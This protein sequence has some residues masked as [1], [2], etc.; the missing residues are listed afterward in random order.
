MS[1]NLWRPSHQAESNP[2][3]GELVNNVQKKMQDGDLDQIDRRC[4]DR[5]FYDE[6]D[7][8]A[9]DEIAEEL[10]DLDGLTRADHRF[11]MHLVDAFSR[12]VLSWGYGAASSKDQLFDYDSPTLRRQAD[13]IDIAVLTGLVGNDI[14]GKDKE[15]DKRA[16]EMS[17]SIQDCRLVLGTAALIATRNLERRWE[18]DYAGFESTS[19][20]GIRSYVEVYADFHGDFRMRETR[21][22]DVIRDPFGTE[23]FGGPEPEPTYIAGYHSVEPY[24]LMNV[25]HHQSK[26]MDGT[27]LT[28]F[29]YTITKRVYEDP[30]LEVQVGN[31]GDWGESS[32]EY[33]ASLLRELIKEGSASSISSLAVKPQGPER[34]V[35]E[36]TQDG[37]FLCNRVDDGEQSHSIVIPNDKIEEFVFSLIKSAHSYGRTSPGSLLRVL[38]TL[39]EPQRILTPKD[40]RLPSDG[41]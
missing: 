5:G 31:F 33:E 10:K 2:V 22:A 40:L 32:G 1:E 13:T 29:A 35:I 24:I 18:E 36:S 19:K 9:L 38:N 7:E 16:K 41:V 8:E 6:D 39:I 14:I 15:I 17:S 3:F 37:I 28:E 30:L 4:Y 11:N 27:L 20:D 25:L 26:R 34:L 12:D 21:Q 23:R